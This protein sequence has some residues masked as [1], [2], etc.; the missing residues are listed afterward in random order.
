MGSGWTGRLAIC[1]QAIVSA[2]VL[3]TGDGAMIRVRQAG[4]T[5][6]VQLA[7]IEAPKAPIPERVQRQGHSYLD[8]SGDGDACETQL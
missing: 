7:C 2:T 5:L 3:P 4:K 8:G 6:S 1:V